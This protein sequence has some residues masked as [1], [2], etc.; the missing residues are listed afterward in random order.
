MRRFYLHRLYL[1]LAVM[2]L[3][4]LL[5]GS[6]HAEPAVPKRT[7][8]V[9]LQNNT[10]KTLFLTHVEL[11]DGC[12]WTPNLRPPQNIPPGASRGWKSEAGL[13][14][15]VGDIEGTVHYSIGSASWRTPTPISPANSAKTNS[16]LLSL[17]HSPDA[18]DVF[19]VAPDG[20]VQCVWY[21]LKVNKWSTPYVV[22]PAKS[23]RSN[24]SL[25]GVCRTPGHMDVFWITPKGEIATK[26]FAKGDWG[27]V[28]NITGP[29]EV[30]DLMNLSVV[31]NDKNWIDV[32]YVGTDHSV[33]SCSWRGAPT[34]HKPTSHSPAN[35][36]HS[37]L[38]A[39]TRTKD[40]IHVFYKNQE[41]GISSVWWRGKW[42]G[43][44]KVTE[45]STMGGSRIDAVAM[46][47]KHLA[48]FWANP[49][50]AMCTTYSMTDKEAGKW[51][52]PYPLS[53]EQGAYLA[54][55][56]VA[57][58]RSGTEI[59]VFWRTLEGAV[60]ATGYTAGGLW[61]KAY[62][63]APAK[64]CSSHMT[65]VSRVGHHIDVFWVDSKG[66]IVTNWWDAK[67]VPEISIRWTNPLADSQYGNKYYER[68][69][70]GFALTH[71][72]GQGSDAKPMYV[73]EPERKRMVKN[74]LPSKDGFK[75]NNDYWD[76]NKIKLPVVT[77][78]FPKPIG[79][80]DLTNS[81]QGLCGGM[82]YTVIDYFQA[83]Q[84]LPARTVAPV[85]ENDALYKYLRNRHLTSFDV[86]GTGPNYINYM[87]PDYPDTDDS[88]SGIALRQKGRSFIIAKE[89]WPKIK[90]DID[91]NRLSPIGLVQSKS[92]NPADLGKHHQ[93][94]VY[95]YNLNG[96]QVTLYYYDPNHPGIDQMELRF[97]ISTLS[98]PIKVNRFIK[99]VHSPMPINTFFRT[100]YK[101]APSSLVRPK[102]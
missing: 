2:T 53:A 46:N 60:M 76:K 79:K 42:N 95:G 82:V 28:R 54:S 45:K 48:V 96:E 99:G 88:T 13:V 22:A 47:P 14:A 74:F 91:A 59:N 8:M 12:N 27:P 4:C 72:D 21:T 66:S 68:V 31:S 25:A 9:T 80:V 71:T 83:G 51:N 50:A 41:E 37:E 85:N 26:A 18:V 100:N 98:D 89:E 1:C 20:S 6:T 35:S 23:T 30:R 56:I 24:T 86:T 3:G 11:G 36:V 70:T 43:P 93:V 5:V 33:K 77:L 84:T 102:S 34:W 65:S 40:E 73:L 10:D 17:S 39:I 67:E 75:F 63:I 58:N 101:P 38:T 57:S 52:I 62:Y 69:P 44:G 81:T 29:N 61:G 15:K 32:F 94:L 78:D 64:A 92:F 49:K 90:T 87:R 19:F 7:T 16:P 97:S 55:P